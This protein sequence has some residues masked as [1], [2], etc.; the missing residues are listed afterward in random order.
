MVSAEPLCLLIENELTLK[1]VVLAFPLRPFLF[2]FFN[3]NE[4][5][6]ILLHDCCTD[7]QSQHPATQYCCFSLRDLKN[8]VLLSHLPLGLEKVRI[9]PLTEGQVSRVPT[10]TGS[11]LYPLQS[12]GKHGLLPHWICSC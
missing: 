7:M 12:L 11:C 2:I 4:P 5:Y 6:V 3:E 9:L 10:Q 8:N 1:A